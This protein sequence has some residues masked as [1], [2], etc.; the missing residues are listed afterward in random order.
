MK[1]I[2]CER[3][4]GKGGSLSQREQEKTIGRMIKE[5]FP[6]S[7]TYVFRRMDSLSEQQDNLKKK[8]KDRIKMF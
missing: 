7:K 8:K 6:D 1:S 5:K 4:G 3:C 2:K